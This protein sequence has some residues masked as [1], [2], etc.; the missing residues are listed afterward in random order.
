MTGGWVKIYRKMLYNPV[1]WKSPDHTA[2]WVW[3]LLM[4]THREYNTLLGGKKVTLMPGQLVTGRMKIASATGVHP[5]K[6]RRVL[7]DFEY[8]GQI[9]IAPSR[10][11]SIVT[12]VNW[13]EYQKSDQ[14]SDQQTDQ[15]FTSH[16]EAI[17]T[18]RRVIHRESDQQTDQPSDQPPTNLRPLYKNN[19]NYKESYLT[20]NQERGR[21]V[22]NSEEELTGMDLI[23]WRRQNT[24][25]ALEGQKGRTQ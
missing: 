23:R 6:V 5:E 9:E 7:N 22:D 11:G 15:P 2:I 25:R 16:D 1:V 13:E 10:N 24:K 14:P 3:L 12:I 21:P 4:A 20:R 18:A 19:K 17:A 8:D